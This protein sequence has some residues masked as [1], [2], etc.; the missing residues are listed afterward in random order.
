LDK[1]NNFI[2]LKKIIINQLLIFIYVCAF[3]VVFASNHYATKS[4]IP[5]NYFYKNEPDSIKKIDLDTIKFNSS[6]DTSV[7][8]NDDFEY[9][10]E[11][12]L[13][14]NDSL[15]QKSNNSFDVPVDYIA[16]DSSIFDFNKQKIYLYGDAH[17]IYENIEL[18][19]DFVELDISRNEVLAYGVK[20]SLGEV[21]GKPIFK[22]NDEEF[23]ADTIRYNFDTKKGLIKVVITK[24]EESFLHGEKTK[25]HSNK[26]V[27]L[28]DGKFTTCDLDHPHYY[29]KIS[30]AVV[31]PDDKIISGPVYMVIE[32]IPTPLGLPFVFFPNT[33]GGSSG[34]IIPT[35]GEEGNR[36]FFLRDAGYYIAISDQL[37]M[38]IMGDIFSK[39]SWGIGLKSNYKV[40]YKYNGNLNFKYNKNVFGYKGLNNYETQS[41]YALRWRFVQDSKFRPNSSFS[42]DVNLSSTAF[43]K[44]NSYNANNLMTNTKQSSISYTNSLPN[45]PFN[46]SAAFRHS[47]NNRDSTVH[48]TLPDISLSTSRLFPFKRQT[49]VG[50]SKWYEKVG[51]TYTMNMTNQ[52][53]SHED[54][55]LN[56]TPDKLLNGFSHRIPISTSLKFLKFTTLTPSFNYN[57]RWYFRTLEKNWV[58]NNPSDPTSTDG[59]LNLTQQNQFSR[60]WDYSTSLNWNTQIYGTFQFKGKN[61]KAIRHV[62]SPSVNFTY[63]PDFG[64]EKFSYYDEYSRIQYNANTGQYDTVSY[65][66]SRFE[67]APYGT[68]QRGGAGSLNFSLGNNLEMKLRN[69]KDTVN[70]EKKIKILESLN[71]TTN[72]NIMA[73]SLNWA[74]V[75][76]SGRTK[77]NFLN[78]NF[79]AVFDP[80]A[81][82]ENPYSGAGMRIN[83]AEFYETGNIFRLTAAKIDLSF[84][85]NSKANESNQNRESQL[86]TLYGYPDHYVDF[87]I[88]W[89]VRINYSLR[90]NKPYFDA[91]T[92]QTINFSG[93]FNLTD[94]W[95]I[96]FSSG[97]DIEENKPSYTTLD[98]YRDLHCWEASV[99]IVPFGTY[100]SY[101]FQINVKAAMLKDLKITKQRSWYDNF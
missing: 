19:A 88:P 91:K 5:I 70:N 80:Y 37:D 50:S 76:M 87:N 51:F 95:K 6:T 73:D 57:E 48:L 1:N 61:L 4:F 38:S 68:P 34:V 97:Y 3:S 21:Q 18:W 66:Y 69:S 81:I 46:F 45:T 101:M 28:V 85:L 52:I 67:S 32:D 94:N 89:N 23:R 83:K 22:E 93:D 26:H 56:I 100:K 36:G 12:Y 59:Y 55:L 29:F 9:F 13:R 25:L 90:Y 33:K 84:N 79:S 2:L 64:V 15:K 60:V 74:P 49:A 14:K 7:Q 44:Y 62:M 63:L 40:R 92:V 96:S 11:K 41:M 24:F 30:K 47:Q 75:N 99:H 10:S 86:Q 71:F 77:I 8:K 16:Q 31:I 58:Y 43:D 39:G 20:D 42:A 82:A 78:V 98:I 54:S 27:H 35:F 53:T 65:T 72:Y 17:I